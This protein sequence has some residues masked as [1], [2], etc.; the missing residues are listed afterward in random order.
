MPKK[1]VAKIPYEKLAVD[2]KIKKLKTKAQKK[3]KDTSKDNFD[4]SIKKVSLLNPKNR[5]RT[6]KAGQYLRREA[7]LNVARGLPKGLEL[8]DK[9]LDRSRQV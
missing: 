3:Y 6:L 9:R 2:D 5:K 4:I 7:K 1:K 8:D